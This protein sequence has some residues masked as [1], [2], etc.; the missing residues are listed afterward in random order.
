MHRVE[1]AF[2]NLWSIKGLLRTWKTI[3]KYNKDVKVRDPLDYLEYDVEARQRMVK[4]RDQILDGTYSPEPASSFE[5]AKSRGPFRVMA[6]L[7]PADR[8]VFRHLTDE[9]YRRAQKFEASGAFFGRRHGGVKP[10]GEK[11]VGP[12]EQDFYELAF[13]IWIR[14]HQYRTHTLLNP[15]KQIL[16]VTDI[17]NY[18]ESIQHDLL[19]EYINPLGLPRKAIGLLGKLLESYKPNSGHSP[20]PRVGLPVDDYD[21]ARQLAHVFLFEHDHRVSQLAG[22]DHYVRWMDDQNVAV[23]SETRARQLVRLLT[24]SLSQQRLVLNTGKTRL[25]TPQQVAVEF[26][27]QA[28]KELDGLSNMVMANRYTQAFLRRRL[29]GIFRR[30]GRYEDEGHW[31]KILKR[32][33][34]LAGRVRWDGL[35]ERAYDDLVH[36]PLLADRIFEYYVALGEFQDLLK[37]FRTFVAN[38]ESLYESV[39]ISFFETLLIAN[40]DRQSAK[41]IRSFVREWVLGRTQGSGKPQSRGVAALV[42]YWLGDGRSVPTILAVLRKHGP[43]LPPPVTRALI[44]SFVAFA[45]SRVSEALEFCAQFGGADVTSLGTLLQRLRTD[46]EVKLTLPDVAFRRPWA[47]GDKVYEARTWLRLEVLTVSS[48]PDVQRWLR[49]QQRRLSGKVSGTCEVRAYNRWAGHIPR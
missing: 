34:G 26:H 12:L 46:S 25:L 39:E 36:Y 24:Q 30:A 19:L 33:Y 28:N 2:E 13:P 8:L 29:S 22:A 45:P 35:K 31:D 15:I 48:A 20:T 49:K 7:S 21:C 27:L 1:K 16:V 32:V 23:E 37:L 43:V 41:L 9:V 14:Y 17:T 38:G 6:V 42:L 3:Q 10:I 44:A 5:L 47:V 18:F 40:I 4:L 11:V